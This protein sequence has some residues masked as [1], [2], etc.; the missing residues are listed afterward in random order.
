MILLRILCL[1]SIRRH[2]GLDIVAGPTGKVC[3]VY[4]RFTFENVGKFHGLASKLVLGNMLSHARNMFYLVLNEI[5]SN[6]VFKG[7]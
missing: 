1:F 4:F 2:S 5:L 3:F 6:K 7:K